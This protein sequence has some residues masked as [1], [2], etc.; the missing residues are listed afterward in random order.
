MSFEYKY[1]ILENSQVLLIKT[2]QVKGFWGRLLKHWMYMCVT[3]NSIAYTSYANARFCYCILLR[4]HVV[5]TMAQI[6]HSVLRSFI[7]QNISIR[8]PFLTVTVDEEQKY[9]SFIIIPAS[10][11]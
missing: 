5:E 3:D 8:C 9:F 4:L 11:N 2:T 6:L 10:Q 7:P 1:Q